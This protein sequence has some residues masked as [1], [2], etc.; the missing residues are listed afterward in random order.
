MHAKSVL[1]SLIFWCI[2]FLTLGAVVVFLLWLSVPSR[3]RQFKK[4]VEEREAVVRLIQEGKLK[5][6]SVGNNDFVELPSEYG[7]LAVFGEAYVTKENGD[8]R[9]SFLVSKMKDDV[10]MFIYVSDAKP[11]LFKTRWGEIAPPHKLREHWFYVNTM[12]CHAKTN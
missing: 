11:P 12:E 2:A 3:E 9:V 6:K 1:K 4:T 5:I 7:S 10:E 8:L